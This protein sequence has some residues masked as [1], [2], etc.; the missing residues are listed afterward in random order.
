M[1]L[2]QLWS[3]LHLSLGYRGG[4]NGF[5][6]IACIASIAAIVDSYCNCTCLVKLDHTLAAMSMTNGDMHW[7]N[8]PCAG[9]AL[10][11]QSLVQAQF[12]ASF[13]LVQAHVST[14]A[15]CSLWRHLAGKLFDQWQT[16]NLWPGCALP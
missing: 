13:S 15:I 2:Q 8:K 1:V 6:Q 7:A 16:W 12:Y 4:S 9:T 10:C 3:L 11:R 5:A 14:I